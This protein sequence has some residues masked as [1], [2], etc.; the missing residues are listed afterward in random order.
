M[1][2]LNGQPLALDTPFTTGDIQYPANWLRLASL[3]EK[4][5]IGITEVDDPV[6]YDDRFYWGLGN[7]KALEDVPQVDQDNNPVLDA[8]GVQLVSKGLKSQLVA[9]LKDTANKLLA[10]TDWMVLRQ[11]SRG[12]GMSHI[13]EDYRTAVIDECARVE[14]AI[15]EAADVSALIEVLA[16]TNWPKVE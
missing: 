7:P 11:L 1:F 10:P 12:V 8:N 16:T 14:T 5:A 9:Q 4:Q 6:P 2:M 13:Y 15:N 3:E